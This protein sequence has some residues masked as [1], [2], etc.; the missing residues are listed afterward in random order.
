ML[1]VKIFEEEVNVVIRGPLERQ[2]TK[3]RQNV[4]RSVI[5]NF[6]LFLSRILFKRMMNYKKIFCKT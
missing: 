5:S 2:P 3:K 4:A 6:I 1:F